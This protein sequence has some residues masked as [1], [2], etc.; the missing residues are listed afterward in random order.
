M[1]FDLSVPSD[2]SLSFFNSPYIGH[3][4]H[5]AVDIY[6]AHGDWEGPAYAPIAGTI[7]KIQRIKMGR[8]KNFDS[9]DYDY[10]IGIAVPENK[11]LV[12][13]ILH[14]K[15]TVEVGQSVEEGEYIGSLLRSRYFN[16]WTGPHYHVEVMH[17]DDFKRSSQS[18]EFDHFLSGENNMKDIAGVHIFEAD[19]EIMQISSN[20]ILLSSKNVEYGILDDY[21]GHEARID[22]LR[23]I[24]DAGIPH[25]A[26]GGLHGINLSKRSEISIGKNRIGLVE[27]I[28]PSS[29]L[30][31]QD[32]SYTINLEG[33]PVRG[34]ST[35]LYSTISVGNKSPPLKVIPLEHS[36]WLATLAE[37]DS[38]K[39]EFTH[40]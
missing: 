6:P 2:A 11:N 13:R 27:G 31:T 12:F 9:P 17:K 23:G 35:Y 33:H 15:P 20:F 10:A 1:G 26:H 37:G 21:T 14:C 5:T 19:W 38:V 24:L 40:Y 32:R 3:V 8:E 28:L 4:N 16:Y 39:L 22:Q 29:I 30:F 7:S 34:F 18:I 36:K 25:Y